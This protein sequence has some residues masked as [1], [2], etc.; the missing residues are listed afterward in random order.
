MPTFIPLL[1]NKSAPITAS[2]VFISTYFQPKAIATCHNQPFGS[3]EI[4][5]KKIK[6]KVKVRTE[7]KLMGQR[8]DASCEAFMAAA[9]EQSEL[10]VEL[11]FMPFGAVLVVDGRVV[12]KA[13]NCIDIAADAESDVT[14]HAE[15][16]LVRKMCAAG[17]SREQRKRATLYTS[18]EPCVMCAGA[19][20]WSGVE[21]LVY[22]CSAKRVHE[23]TPGGFDVPIRELFGRAPKDIKVW[24]LVASTV[25]VW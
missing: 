19:I 14:R 20:V 9:I 23:I 17:I 24:V 10:G 3:I 21:T 11:G 6:I 13:H 22:G 16:E 25:W 18:T 5:I 7:G 15:M 8:D 4:K 1:P 12:L 2:T